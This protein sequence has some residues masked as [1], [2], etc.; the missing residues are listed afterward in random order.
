M[1]IGGV[2][3]ISRRCRRPDQLSRWASSCRRRSWNGCVRT[4]S[5][6]SRSCSSSNVFLLHRRAGSWRYSAAIVVVV[7]LI[8]PLGAAF[9]INPVH[10]GSSS[11]S[12]LELG[13]PDAVGRAQHLP[14]VL[15]LQAS[16]ISRCAARRCRSWP[17]SASGT[18]HHLRP[19]A[20]DGGCWRCCGAVGGPLPGNSIARPSVCAFR[21]GACHAQHVETE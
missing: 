12:N 18:G 20:D 10:L 13:L 1:V 11:S 3:V 7:P 4:S 17:S 21:G 6:G 14:G 19:L 5:R 15:S 8:V 16:R 9:G 2:L